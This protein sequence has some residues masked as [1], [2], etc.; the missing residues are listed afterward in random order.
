MCHANNKQKKTGVAILVLD[1]ID[2]R[3][4]NITRDEVFA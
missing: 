4:R 3:E 1:K 2:F